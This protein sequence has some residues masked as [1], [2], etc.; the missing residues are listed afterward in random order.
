[1]IQ[2]TIVHNWAKPQKRD[3]FIETARALAAQSRQEPGCLSYQF[4]E[5]REDPLHLLFIEAWESEEALQAHRQTAH[6]QQLAPR[7]GPCTSR[8]HQVVRL[9]PLG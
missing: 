8:P 5:D 3:E 1:M 6:F 2:H 9:A 4:L 7:L